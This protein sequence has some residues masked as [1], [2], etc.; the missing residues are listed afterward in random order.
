MKSQFFVLAMMCFG[1]TAHSQTFDQDLLS[2]FSALGSGV[3]FGFADMSQSDEFNVTGPS[4]G[5]GLAAKIDSDDVAP[6]YLE[7]SGSWAWGSNFTSSTEMQGSDAYV[8]AP[9][10]SP[11]GTIDLSTEISATGP[12]AAATVQITDNSGDTASIF[13]SAF[14]PFGTG[15]SVAQFATTMTDAGGIYAA[16]TT[17]GEAITAT[18]Y[19]GMFDSTGVS[20]MGSGNESNTTTITTTVEDNI[21]FSNQVLYLSKRFSL[22]ENWILS[23][24]IGPNYRSFDRSNTTRTTINIDGNRGSDS[25]I[26]TVTMEDNWKLNGKYYGA[27]L[28]AGLTRKINDA[29]SIN[30]GAEAGLT[31][32][33]AKSETMELVNFAGSASAIPGERKSLN[34]TARVGRITGALTHVA[35]NG[36]IIVFGGYLDY[37]SDVPYLQF[38]TV[39]SPNITTAGSSVGLSGNGDTYRTHSIQ[40]KKMIGSGLNLSFVFL[41]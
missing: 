6:F 15:N 40:K 38:E 12:T 35:E 20:F 34:G 16:L 39:G 2:P 11:V 3:T 23:P 41:F 1:S 17:D 19:G 32:F 25:S 26:P 33:N 14:S 10:R 30:F 7:W 4:V 9:R 28:G 36:A 24:K 8:Y 22:D 5:F 29:W 13:S 21:K 18:S 27:V 37:M 31:K